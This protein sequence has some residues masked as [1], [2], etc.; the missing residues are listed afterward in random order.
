MQ[1]SWQ[2]A[3]RHTSRVAVAADDHHRL[4]RMHS[5]MAAGQLMATKRMGE[6]RLQVGEGVLE[7]R[8][9]ALRQAVGVE[10]LLPGG[11]LQ[12]VRRLQAAPGEFCSSGP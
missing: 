4:G 11:R 9:G 10:R 2:C 12:V 7:Q 1:L 5:I 6:T 3:A 8:D